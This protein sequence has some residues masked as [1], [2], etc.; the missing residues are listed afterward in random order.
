MWSYAKIGSTSICN[1]FNKHD[2]HAILNIK[3]NI[4][5]H[6]CIC[7]LILFLICIWDI[8]MYWHFC[9]YLRTRS[10]GQLLETLRTM[11]T[12]GRLMTSQIREINVGQVCCKSHQNAAFVE[13]L[14]FN[15]IK[16]HCPWEMLS[17]LILKEF[18]RIGFCLK[19]N[20]CEQCNPLYISWQVCRSLKLIGH[21][22]HEKIVKN[23]L[24]ILHD[25]NAKRKKN[26]TFTW[27]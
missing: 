17:I 18:Y 16:V 15:L 11:K 26:K 24:H 23:R 14:I 10:N 5:L 12:K 20:N 22:G 6:I 3:F 9:R 8:Y 19:Q 21:L 7:S 4:I 1:D 13:I 27:R 2:H 25:I